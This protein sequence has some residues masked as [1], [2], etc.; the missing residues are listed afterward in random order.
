MGTNRTEEVKPALAIFINARGAQ[1]R[2]R[3]LAH[4]DRTIGERIYTGSEDAL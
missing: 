1:A 3:R 2:W 4:R